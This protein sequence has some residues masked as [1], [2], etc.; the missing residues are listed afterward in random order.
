MSLQA[1]LIK[2]I[3]EERHRIHPE[4][5]D[6]VGG[7]SEAEIDKS[8]QTVIEKSAAIGQTVAQAAGQPS[9]DYVDAVRTGIGDQPLP[10][11]M[12]E[13]ADYRRRTGIGQGRNGYGIFGPGR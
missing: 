9:A 6:Y 13:Y 10:E 7:N 4:L 5:L 1:Y 11:S 2:R 12:E 3:T 8:I